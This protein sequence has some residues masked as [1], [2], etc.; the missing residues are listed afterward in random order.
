MKWIGQHIYDLVSKFRNDVIIEAGNKLG[1]GTTSPASLLH[2]AG[3]VQV[4]VDD[5]G[6][7][8]KFFGAT[9]GKYLLWDESADALQIPDST[10][11]Y[12]GTG[13]DLAVYHNGTNSYLQNATGN[14]EIIQNTDDGDII[15]SSDDG[16]GGVETY[17]FLDGSSGHTTFPDGKILSLGTGRDLRFYHDGS[18]GQIQEFTGDLK[19][20]NNADDK[21]IILMSDD[22]SGGTTAYLTLD[23][24]STVTRVHKNMRFDDSA[25]VQMGASSDLSFVHNGSN[26]FI[27][28]TTGNLTIQQTADDGDIIFQSDDGSGGVEEYFR[29]DGSAGGANPVTIFPDNSYIHLGSGQDMVLGHTGSD[30]YFTNNTGDLYIQNKADDKDIIFRSD[31]GSGGAA[32]YLTLDGSAGTVVVD[33]PLLINGAAIQASPNLYGSIIKLLP[34]D[35]AANI[36]G[37]NTK[38]GVGY[39]DT[40]GSAYGMK[41]ANADTELFAFVSIPEGMKATHV[42]VFDKDDRALE[43]FEVQINATSLTSKGSGNCNTTLDITDVNATATNFL[44]IKITTTATTDK[45]FGGQ[46]TI[47]AQ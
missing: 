39:T 20:V 22:G 47:A 4:G 43:V 1:I 35:F 8:V 42:D 15:F 17:F 28:N 5:T 29:L 32:A 25:Y 36:D 10:Y 18:S 9:S 31:D 14:L 19:I 27:S 34:S 24:S 12:F 2:V 46:V 45:V 6:H 21:D 37:G 23:G 7:D 33:K 38:F 16:S 13:I 40:A 44:A 3:T 11:L 26:S 30:T 41:V